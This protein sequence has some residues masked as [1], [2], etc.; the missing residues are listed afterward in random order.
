[1]SADQPPSNVHDIG[2]ADR[3][4]RSDALAK[5]D[6]AGALRRGRD[7]F[8]RA[9]AEPTLL[10]MSPFYVQAGARH[11]V[12][13]DTGIGKSLIVMR[14]AV[15]VALRGHKVIYF[16]GESYEDEFDDRLQCIVRGLGYEPSTVE[17]AQ[18]FDTLAEN[19]LDLSSAS[20]PL[21]ESRRQ[22]AAIR[23]TEDPELVIFDPY[24][25]YATGSE[26]DVE[27]A[28]DF[29]VALNTLF[30]SRGVAVVIVHHSGKGHEGSPAETMR[31]SSHL[32]SWS[33]LTYRVTAVDL[34]AHCTRMTVECKKGRPKRKPELVSYDRVLSED[35]ATTWFRPAS[36][37]TDGLLQEQKA[38]DKGKTEEAEVDPATIVPITALP[39]F[40][41]DDTR[42]A[43]EILREAMLLHDN[44]A[45]TRFE[46]EHL[47][48]LTKSPANNLLKAFVEAGIAIPLGMTKHNRS[49][50][51]AYRYAPQK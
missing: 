29:T 17:H 22:L 35:Y 32:P 39:A 45:F 9:V 19:L 31:G 18:I 38:K 30:I 23:D 14:A 16:A 40:A 10:T 26:N 8:T 47:T 4:R 6:L 42:N 41:S 11:I 46:V 33:Q 28:R 27:S 15:E 50:L 12:F 13:G 25:T 1:M 49:R 20:F 51:Q 7:R 5:G 2:T 34:D 48:G 44:K 36:G 21:A 3:N 24:V 43:R 37:S